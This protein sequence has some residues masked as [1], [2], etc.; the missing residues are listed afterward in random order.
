MLH[1]EYIK[2][3]IVML[4]QSGEMCVFEANKQNVM[5]LKL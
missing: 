4:L 3:S 2:I 1:V 5:M